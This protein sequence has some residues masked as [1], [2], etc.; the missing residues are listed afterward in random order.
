MRK[1][2]REVRRLLDRD[3]PFEHVEAHIAELHEPTEVKALLWIFA[4][5]DGDPFFIAQALGAP[6]A[7]DDYTTTGK[8]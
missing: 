4:W 6:L 8:D 5:T 1:A 3:V 2:V 7:D